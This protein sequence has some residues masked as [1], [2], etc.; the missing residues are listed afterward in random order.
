MSVVAPLARADLLALVAEAGRA[1]SV[2]NIQ[3]AR[4]AAPEPGVLALR[5]DPT[6]TLP[7]ADPSGH[8]VRL[9][10]GAAGEG[11]AIALSRRGFAAGP[12]EIA[13][14]GARGSSSPGPPFEARLS[15]ARGGPADPLAE[16]VARRASF[17]GSFARAPAAALDALERRLAPSGVS[18]VRGRARI[19]E[20]AAL[21][22]EAAEEFLLDPRYWRETWRWIRLSPAHPDWARDGLNADALALSGLERVAGRWLMAPPCFE[23]MRRLGLARVLISERSKT[24]GAGALLLLTAPIG[25]DPFVTGRAFYRRWLEVTASGLALCPMSVLADSQ[26]ANAEIRRQFAIPAGSRLVNV[27]RVGMAPAGFPARPTP[28]LPAEELLAPPGA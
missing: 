9:S 27:L 4:W 2:H 13:A 1:P 22:D 24:P 20:L 28:R 14:R 19:R 17:R 25:E 6:R 23:W 11:M 8:D 21:A 16:A 3:P 10:L 15:F 7:I 18:V 5:A 12:P 26:R